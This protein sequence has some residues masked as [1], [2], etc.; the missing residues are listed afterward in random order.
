MTNREKEII[1]SV[2]SDLKNLHKNCSKDEL[3]RYLD[4]TI[5][6]A[7]ELNHSDEFMEKLYFMRYYID[8][9]AC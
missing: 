2:K 9:V 7:K 6:L 4:Y 1:E 8:K 5:I 3:V